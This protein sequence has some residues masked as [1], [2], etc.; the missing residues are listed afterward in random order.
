ML[1]IKNNNF[2]KVGHIVDYEL[3]NGILLFGG[4]WNGEVY[5]TSWDEKNKKDTN[6]NYRPVY[7]YEEENIDI[8]NIEEN[9]EEWDKAFEII[10]FEEI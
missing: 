10:G 7:R 2:K 1:K 5:L 6:C 3:E 8:L 4:D 9:S